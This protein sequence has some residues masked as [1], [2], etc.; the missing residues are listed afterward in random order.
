MIIN[1]RNLCTHSLC[2]LIVRTHFLTTDLL[3]SHKL[4]SGNALES[5]QSSS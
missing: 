5:I 4:K 2:N 3:G 1:K